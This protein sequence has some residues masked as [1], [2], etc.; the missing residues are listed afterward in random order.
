MRK[1]KGL[2]KSAAEEEPLSPMGRLYHVPGISCFIIAT[3]GFKTRID[4][5]AFKHGLN[6]TLI[7]HP[8]F[9]SKLVFDAKETSKPIGWVRTNVMVDD[10]IIVP[11]LDPNMDSLDTIVEDYISSISETTMDMSRPLWEFH[12]LDVETSEATST[13]VFRFH[14]SLGDGVSLISLLL[15]CSRC[16]SDPQRLPSLPIS[17]KKLEKS[18]YPRILRFFFALL[19][20]FKVLWNT[21]VDVALV[22]ATMIFLEDTENPLK[23]AP[24]IERTRK[25]FVHRILSFDDIKLVKNALGMTV[26]DVVIGITQAGLTHYLIEKYVDVSGQDRAGN[27][28]RGNNNLFEHIRLRAILAMNL[29]PTTMIE[30]LAEM[31]EAESNTGAK[32]GNIVASVILPIQIVLNDDPLDY[33]HKVKATIDRKKQSLQVW[34]SYFTTKFLINTLGLKAA[35]SAFCIIFSNTTL[36]FSNLAGPTEEISLYGHPVIFLAPTVY[37]VPQALI[38]HFQSYMDKLTI[39]L[40]VDE[41]VIRDPEKLCNKIEESLILVRDRK[42]VV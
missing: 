28:A 26:N 6:H 22:T 3:F 19:M 13:G 21:L 27:K 42:S 2:L 38:V 30:G 39:S 32:W 40:A 37:G 29:R 36:S 14:H 41:N 18:N 9:S 15:A 25:R 5:E 1:S 24:G 34:V 31:M 16:T 35:A 17:K 33:I 11:S 20:F 10:H 23:G 12:V 7:R 4:V 8:R